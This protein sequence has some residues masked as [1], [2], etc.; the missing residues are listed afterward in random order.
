MKTVE[1][2]K[3]EWRRY[4]ISKT[5]VY[6][7]QLWN[8]Q[9]DRKGE[10][11]KQEERKKKDFRPSSHTGA[12]LQQQFWWS[13][14]R[15]NITFL[16]ER[17]WLMVTFWIIKRGPTRNQCFRTTEWW[18]EACRWKYYSLYFSSTL[19]SSDLA[20]VRD[21]LAEKFH[22]N[23]SATEKQ[24]WTMLAGY[25]RTLENSRYT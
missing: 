13:P 4:L 24:Y 22:Q 23:N 9:N 16:D 2:H 15:T 17:Q 11:K 25:Y 19:L 1:A 21:E 8:D 10:G 3:P 18:G 7:N 12:Y 14:R 6:E 5:E 20:E